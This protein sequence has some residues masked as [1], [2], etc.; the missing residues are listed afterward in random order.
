MN[1]V[2]ISFAAVVAVAALVVLLGRRG[3]TRQRAMRGLLD[4]AD[5]L[6]A[7]L[8]TARQEIV[9]IAGDEV[10]DPIRDALKEMLRQRLW[11]REH[12]R[13]ASLGELALVRA[14]IEEAR[15]RIDQQL[16]QIER[17]RGA[18]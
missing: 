14:S 2:Q 3:R 13:T 18:L 10:S 12:G 16:A 15:V 11:L 9:A 7:R 8:R 6:E 1:A 5:A 17:A 4:A